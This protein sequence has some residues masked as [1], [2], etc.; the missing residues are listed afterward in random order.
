MIDS[1]R[2]VKLELKIIMCVTILDSD[3]TVEDIETRVR[4]KIFENT[5][6]YTYIGSVETKVINFNIT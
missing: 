5:E 4:K 6:I 1:L 3:L 2:Y